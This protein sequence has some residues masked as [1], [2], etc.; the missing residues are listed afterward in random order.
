MSEQ[1]GIG[2]LCTV[3]DTLEVGVVILDAHACVLHSN[4]WLARRSGLAAEALLGRPFV[5][6]FPAARGSRL[7]QAIEHAIRDRL[8]SLLS[9]ALHGTLLPLYQTPQD[10]DRERRM[11]QMIHVMPLRDADPKAACLI[12]ISDMTAN[13]SRERLLRQ[14][15]ETL[16]RAT[17]QDALTGV[18]NRRQFDETLAAEFL[19]A[20]R[21]KQSL[22]LMIIDIDH[23]SAYN[24]HYSRDQ[25]DARL[26]ELARLLKETVR[27]GIDLLSRYGGDEF[28]FIL[29]ELSESDIVHLAET[30][31]LRVATLAIAHVASSVAAHLTVSIGCAVM[32]PDGETDIHTL[33]S[34]AD[35]ALYQAK[36]DGR[37]R[38]I[39]FSPDDGS[40]KRCD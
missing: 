20:Q 24:G 17:T 21:S 6:T 13:I 1:L 18:A 10:R 4:R 40:F 27:P 29:P 9:P 39:Y 34:S 23:F 25:G 12:Q 19:K 37:N 5:E 14:Q 38:A 31:R 35:V 15:S 28:A 30:L 33:L 16:R 11:Q 26:S 8:P 2:S 7:E 3:L 36:H 32:L 22:G